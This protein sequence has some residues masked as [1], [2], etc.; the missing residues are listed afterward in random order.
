[1]GWHEK[2]LGKPWKASPCPPHNYNCAVLAR[3]VQL[4]MKG[5]KL[6]EIRADANDWRECVAEFSPALFGCRPLAE[7]ENPREFDVAF[8]ARGRYLD[9][10]GVAVQT[11]DGMLILHCLEGPGVV[12]ECLG[13]VM[14]RGYSKMGWFRHKGMEEAWPLSES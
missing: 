2:Y 8:F 13:D 3:S 14:A 1:M 5:G 7:G 6:R 11:I 4:D 9:H 10:C 12:L